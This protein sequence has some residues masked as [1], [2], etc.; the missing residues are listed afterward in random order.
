MSVLFVDTS[1]LAKR[2]L[3]E[4]GAPWI[5]TLLAPSAGNVVVISALTQV[6]MASLFARRV[7][8]GSLAAADAAAL[9]NTFLHHAA[10]EYLIIAVDGG[11]LA[12]ARALVKAHPLRALDAVQV[13]GARAACA[14]LGES[15]TVVSGDHVLLASAVAEGLRGE[16]PASHA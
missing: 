10:E 11:V 9:E 14:V 5:R 12:D 13:A 2:Y 15:V 4:A 6:E 3:G 8:E 1:A 16:D 7:R